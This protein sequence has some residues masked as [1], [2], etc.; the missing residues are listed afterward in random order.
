MIELKWILQWWPDVVRNLWW[1]LMLANV[2]VSS[3]KGQVLT[4]RSR[5]ERPSFL[6]RSFSKD[7]PLLYPASASAITTGRAGEADLRAAASVQA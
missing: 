2:P 3:Q 5:P 6:G 4:H 7:T 1:L